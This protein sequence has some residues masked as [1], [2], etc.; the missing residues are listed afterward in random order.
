MESPT[1]IFQRR[2]QTLLSRPDKREKCGSCGGII[3]PLSGE[4]RCS[5]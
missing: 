2:D 4:C 1:E 5:A 3:E